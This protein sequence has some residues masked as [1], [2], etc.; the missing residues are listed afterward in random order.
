LAKKLFISPFSQA[1]FA[2]ELHHVSMKTGCYL[3]LLISLISNISGQESKTF[4]IVDESE[5][6]IPFAHVHFKNTMNGTIANGNGEFRI[7]APN[8]LENPTLVISSVGYK[9]RE[10]PFDS[11]TSKMITLVED[12]VTLQQVVVTPIDYERELLNN[13]IKNIPVNYPENNERHFGFAREFVFWDD[14]EKQPVYIVESTLEATKNPYN[15]KNDK[16][17]VKVSQG[18]VYQD[19]A[20]MDSLTTNIIAGSHHINRFDAVGVRASLLGN[21]DP[22]QLEV[23]D[24]LRLDRKN[25]YK[26]SFRKNN[27]AS[28]Y[29]LIMDSSFAITKAFFEYTGSYPPTYRH[30]R[31]EFM[32][33]QVTYEMA[34][35]NKWRYKYSKYH[36]AF[37][38]DRLLNLKS[39]F[40]STKTERND[41]K[42]PYLERI[43]RNDIFMEN[44]GEYDSTFWDGYSII[45]PNENVEKLFQ[46]YSPSNPNGIDSLEVNESIKFPISTYFELS[47]VPIQVSDIFASYS[48]GIVDFTHQG[49]S[50]TDF[51]INFVYGFSVDIGKQFWVGV[52]S[53]TTFR[54][55]QLSSFD[56]EVAK[57]INLNPK[58]R[59]VLI[60][61]KLII[62]H[63]WINHP[64]GSIEHEQDYEV[65][66]K[67]FDSGKTNLYLH[68]RGFHMSPMISL[69]IEKSRV[70]KYFLSFGTNIFL[71]RTTG[72]VFNEDDQFFLTKKNEFLKEGQEN[73]DLAYN[74]SLLAIN[75]MVHFGL[76]LGR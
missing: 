20:Q 75:W 63:Q 52:R 29:L 59:P 16:G 47:Y 73:L 8:L 10:I 56:F 11:Y 9:K 38:Y 69:G 46:D 35:D 62:G 55:R 31:R 21:P 72:V 6:P 3:I 74:S 1:T 17:H 44:I 32:N 65:N 39:E 24:T 61:P 58:G 2:I 49:R 76:Y 25:L 42:I 26:L 33:Y 30:S 40:V 45:I 4:Q 28:G 60:S 36:T 71:T 67:K 54:D 43:Q 23:T 7:K 53:N 70:V 18:R 22:Y 48:N 37:K 64:I 15:K 34:E 57:N 51:S 13:A 27:N 41:A 66:G 68:E 12:V 50:E 14:A 19:S 5:E